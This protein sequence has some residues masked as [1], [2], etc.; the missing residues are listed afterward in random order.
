MVVSGLAVY[1]PDWVDQSNVPSK[2]SDYLGFGVFTAVPM[3]NV[4]I[5]AFSA[6]N[7]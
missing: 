3:K 4:V 2:E 5:M 7:L 6:S 1:F